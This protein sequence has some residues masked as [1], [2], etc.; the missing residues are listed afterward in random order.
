MSAFSVTQSLSY[1][2]N[3]SSSALDVGWA[4]PSSE[5]RVAIDPGERRPMRRCPRRDG[6][7]TGHRNDDD[8]RPEDDDDV[9]PPSR[10]AAFAQP[11]VD[12]NASV[13]VGTRADVGLTG[14]ATAAG[15]GIV[16]LI[17]TDAFAPEC[18]A[19]WRMMMT[20]FCPDG[21]RRTP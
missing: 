12:A 7:S 10:A 5:A 16:L 18:V 19:P 9:A 15:A 21:V 2:S 13:R 14:A 4:Y 6:A 11:R 1:D 3:P 20:F 8:V 17:R